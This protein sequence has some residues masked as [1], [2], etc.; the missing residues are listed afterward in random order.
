MATLSLCMMVRDEESTL[1]RAI[2]SFNG[3]ADEVVVVDTGS[4]DG[5]VDLA[6][7]LGA[8]VVHHAWRDSFSAARNAGF[9]ACTGDWVFGLDA[10]E[11]LLPESREEV[12]RLVEG[13]TAQ[14]HWIVRRDFTPAGYSEMPFVRLGRRDL[15]RRMVGRIHERFD[16][17]LTNVAQSGIVLEHDGYMPARKDARYRRNARLL[18]LELRDRPGQAYYLADLTHCYW[19]L[20][21]PR[22]SGTLTKTMAAVDLNA[23]RSPLPL[24]IPLLEIVLGAPEATLPPGVTHGAAETLAERWYP[25]SVPLLVARARVAFGR[26]DLARAAELGERAVGAWDSGD[27]DRTISFDPAIVGAE[28]RLNLGVALASVGR[29]SLAQERL[30]EA[31]RD[32]SFAELAQRNLRVIRSSL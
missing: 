12:L 16:P 8:R 13:S 24:V 7:S 15:D 29:T 23:P 28:L 9:D 26:G 3:I 11:R 22:W 4:R 10:D 30:E 21:D 31:A 6:R 32:P 27:Y 25:K 20:R 2:G 5:T 18:E 19:M 14:A 17:P 1:A